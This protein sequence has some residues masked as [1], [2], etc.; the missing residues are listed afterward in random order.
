MS[1]TPLVSCIVPVFNGERHLAE[2]I[3]SIRAQ[4]YHRLEIIVVDDGSTDA[5]GSKVQELGQALRYLWQANAGPAAA[6]NTGIAAATGDLVA[7]LDA[8]DLWHPQKLSRQVARLQS[9]PTLDF[10]LTHI[11]NFWE[12]DLRD[13]AELLRGHF[14]AQPIAGY[15]SVTLVARRR[16]FERAGLYDATLKHGADAD[17]FARV[18]E[19]GMSAAML[20]EVLVYRRLHAENRSRVW[21]DRSREEIL[22]VMKA[23]VD[24]RRNAT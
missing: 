1:P 21:S 11:Q 7:F 15:T 5:T 3:G 12:D 22:R 14:R 18:E 19:A 2:A 10:C 8:D 16:V 17:W 24:R 6:R 13:E 4:T 20:D 9:E 23:I